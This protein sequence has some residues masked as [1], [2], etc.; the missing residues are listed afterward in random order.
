MDNNI[1][2]RIL[3]AARQGIPS[4]RLF[5]PEPEAM[6]GNPEKNMKAWSLT[7]ETPQHIIIDDR[8]EG[9]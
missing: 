6:A 8:G 9:P 3:M 2:C 5:N 1:Y 4:F 7:T